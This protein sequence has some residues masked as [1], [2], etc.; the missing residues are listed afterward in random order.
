M[1]DYVIYGWSLRDWIEIEG[2]NEVCSDTGILFNRFC[3]FTF[4][5]GFTS[6]NDE[7]FINLPSELSEILNRPQRK[8]CGKYFLGAI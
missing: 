8:I 4:G 1:S 2:S 6:D 7:N 3:G 5:G